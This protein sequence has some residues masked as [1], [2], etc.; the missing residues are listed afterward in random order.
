MNAIRCC[1][2]P[3][4]ASRVAGSAVGNT[5]NNTNVTKMTA[6]IVTIPHNTRRM[7]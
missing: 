4:P 5:R 6:T 3:L 2:A 7:M 1:V